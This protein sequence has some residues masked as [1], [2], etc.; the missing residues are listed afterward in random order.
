MPK[1]TLKIKVSVLCPNIWISRQYG[2]GKAY[3]DYCEFR[4][5]CDG[6]GAEQLFYG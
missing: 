5:N 4:I 1:K 6:I 2:I 3:Y